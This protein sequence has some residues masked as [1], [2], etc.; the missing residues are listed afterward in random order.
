[1][2]GEAQKCDRPGG[3]S[4]RGATKPLSAS[5]FTEAGFVSVDSRQNGSFEAH[6]LRLQSTQ[7]RSQRWVAYGQRKSVNTSTVISPK[8]NPAKTIRNRRPPGLSQ[9]SSAVLNTARSRRKDSFARTLS[10]DRANGTVRC[11]RRFRVWQNHY[12]SSWKALFKSLGTF[13]TVR[14]TS[15]IH[16][17]RPSSFLGT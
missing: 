17:R 12:Q 3:H 11:T 5:V 9:G 6:A 15:A 8:G 7:A 16:R 14:A 13:S 2:W 10:R 1:M 4:S